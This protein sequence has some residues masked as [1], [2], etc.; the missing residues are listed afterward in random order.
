MSIFN[1]MTSTANSDG[2][3]RDLWA[4]STAS[5]LSSPA[6]ASQAPSP[7]LTSNHQPSQSQS[8]SQFGRR[9]VS[10]PHSSLTSIGISSQSIDE[11]SPLQTLSNSSLTMPSP[12]DSEIGS[13]L[14]NSATA[15][16][17][18]SLVSGPAASNLIHSNNSSSNSNIFGS[19]TNA[20]STSS[21]TSSSASLINGSN[22]NASIINSNA[23]PSSNHASFIQ[24]SPFSNIQQP[25]AEPQQQQ[26]Q[27]RRFTWTTTTL[28]AESGP[29]LSSG[30]VINN[31][32]FTSTQMLS[33]LPKY[34]ESPQQQT[35]IQ[36]PTTLHNPYAA[37]FYP[38][39][40]PQPQ[41]HAPSPNAVAAL[42]KKLDDT[43]F[44]LKSEFKLLE[45]EN[46]RLRFQLKQYRDDPNKYGEDSSAVSTPSQTPISN[47]GISK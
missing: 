2:V 8:Q 30:A 20:A 47:A 23:N 38:Q 12:F 14:S 39:S 28:G 16:L 44:E 6:S 21:N 4:T 9:S 37:G 26:L 1:L 36:T 11:D 35:P 13:A 22:T 33:S 42:F 5:I 17:P 7:L 41:L 31:I 46:S 34:R 27:Q 10:G 19:L 24:S 25:F 29:M 32:P 43:V 3:N 15:A 40:Q 45:L 18:G